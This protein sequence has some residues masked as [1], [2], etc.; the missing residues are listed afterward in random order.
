MMRS[1]P[2]KSSSPD[3]LAS[4][5]HKRAKTPPILQPKKPL[6]ST[7]QD[8]DHNII[9]ALADQLDYEEREKDDEKKYEEYKQEARRRKEEHAEQRRKQEEERAKQATQLVKMREDKTDKKKRLAAQRRKMEREASEQSFKEAMAEYVE[10]LDRGFSGITLEDDRI[11]DL[12]REKGIRVAEKEIIDVPLPPFLPIL[13]PS[14]QARVDAA[15]AIKSE[16][17]T[18]GKS[19]EGVEISRKDIGRILP[20]GPLVPGR[21]PWLNDEV[22]NA[23]Y[24]NLCAR[25]NEKDGYVKSPTTVP[26]WVAYTTQWYKNVTERGINSIATWSRRKQVKG[27]KLLRTE[28]IFFPTNTGAHWTLLAI[29]GTNKTIEYLDSMNASGWTSKKTINL[30]LEW[31]KMELGTQFK[32]NEWKILHTSSSQQSNMNDCGVFACLNGLALVKGLNDGSEAMF[33]ATDMPS[34][35]RIMVANLLN[36]GFKDEFDI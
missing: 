35:R 18:L 9:Y 4:D 24:A 11:R 20:A 33:G 13:S 25:L 23:W 2:A 5:P 28:R 32:E 27:D 34:A 12:G 10:L 3:E 31:L 29:S 17:S 8:D 6:H 22:V 26:R 16:T 30:A 1:R 14:W 15:L 19:V 7:I 36:G 21:E